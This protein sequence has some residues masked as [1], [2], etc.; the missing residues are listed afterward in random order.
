MDLG[1][2][3]QVLNF[4]FFAL[5]ILFKIS[6]LYKTNTY[7]VTRLLKKKEDWDTPSL[8]F[9]RYF[10]HPSLCSAAV[11]ICNGINKNPAKQKALS[12]NP[13]KQVWGLRWR[14]QRCNIFIQSSFS[15]PLRQLCIVFSWALW[16]CTCS[17]F[18]YFYFPLSLPPHPPQVAALVPKGIQNTD[19]ATWDKTWDHTILPG[20]FNC[21]DNSSHTSEGQ[22][23]TVQL[24]VMYKCPLTLAGGWWGKFGVR[25]HVK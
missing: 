10:F 24:T 23:P 12:L 15:R 9:Q 4:F 6:I 18:F 21:F 19:D 13:E 16:R 20:N 25:C 2:L 17:P 22:V 11:A 3:N 8:E 7:V 14:R 5:V 1:M